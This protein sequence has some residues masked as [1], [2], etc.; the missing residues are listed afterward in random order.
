MGT[1]ARLD[2]DEAR[3][4]LGEE[5]HDLTATE[6]ATEQDP[7]IL[8]DAVNL[9][10]VLC[11]IETDSDDRHG[12]LLRQTLHPRCWSRERPHHQGRSWWRSRAL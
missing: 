2:P 9:E 11:D 7:A 6:L 1:G 4:Q 12:N 10:H 3:R 5:R 8:S